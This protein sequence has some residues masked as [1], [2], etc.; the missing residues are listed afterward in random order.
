VAKRLITLKVKTIFEGAEKEHF[1]LRH[2]MR[3]F[4]S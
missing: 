4:F 3:F 2:K 1:G